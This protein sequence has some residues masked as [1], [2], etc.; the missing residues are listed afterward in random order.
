MVMLKCKSPKRSCLERVRK[1]F[2]TTSK[3]R[4]SSRAKFTTLKAVTGHTRRNEFPNEPFQGYKTYVFCLCFREKVNLKKDRIVQHIQSMKHNN[5]KEK[6]A[7]R[8]QKGKSVS[9]FLDQLDAGE[10]VGAS[11][12]VLQT[13]HAW[14]WYQNGGRNLFPTE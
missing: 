2:G 9:T 11:G 3:L 8:L 5:N 6:Y 1:I 12:A 4:S 14:V 10:I 7:K 13:P